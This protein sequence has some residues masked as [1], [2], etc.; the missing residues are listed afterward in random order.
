M[1]E[2]NNETKE[3]M[4][5]EEALKPVAEAAKPS[6]TITKLFDLQALIA[7]P[8]EIPIELDGQR[9]VLTARRLT[10][11]ERRLLVE[12]M[13]KIVPPPVPGD[14]TGALN[15]GDMKYQTE[16]AK[17][18]RIARAKLVYMACPWVAEGNPGLLDDTKIVDYVE[19]ILLENI[20]EI[21]EAAVSA[22]GI[23]AGEL[24]GFTSPGGPGA[25]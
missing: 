6:V 1:K 10:P 23:R 3:T 11:R 5:I 18:R 7:K 19:G 13:Q 24:A 8:L 21:L 2:D 17:A 20:L 9:V 15:F 4:P 16:L 12:P 22:E 14:R 25:N